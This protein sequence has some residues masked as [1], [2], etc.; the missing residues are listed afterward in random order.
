[1]VLIGS[2]GAVV[3]LACTRP[4]LAKSI[5]GD[6]LIKATADRLRAISGSN[7]VVARLGGDEFVL[8]QHN[9]HE[10]DEVEMARRILETMA[11]P[12]DLNGHAVTVTTSVGVGLAPQDGDTA[13]VLLKSA[14]VAMYR[15][16]GDGRNCIRFFIPGMDAELQARLKL[17]HAIREAAVNDA[18]ELHFRSIASP[19][20]IGRRL[21][22]P[23]SFR[24]HSER[25]GPH[26]QD[27]HQGDPRSLPY[28]G[29]LAGP[30]D[31]GRQPLTC[32]ILG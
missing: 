14:D 18:S 19:S 7:N 2:R 25:N 6:S 11:E 29:N 15:A 17:E 24:S 5:A 12:F 22:T 27:C 31:R 9:F 32:A 10:V 8:V 13:G 26:Q 1:M 21:R 23:S 16:K 3:I 30:F 4:R 20:I 28:S